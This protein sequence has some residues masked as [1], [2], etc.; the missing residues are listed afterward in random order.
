MT[1]DTTASVSR[2]RGTGRRKRRAPATAPG[3]I[4]PSAAAPSATP[5]MAGKMAGSATSTRSAPCRPTPRAHNRRG[6]ILDAAAEL[7][8]R[9][10]FHAASMREIGAAAGML[11]G[12]LYYHFPSK[13]ELLLA[14]YE[15]GVRRIAE[16]LDAALSE[17]DRPW[18][19]LEAAC[20]AHLEMLLEAG[21]DY[22]QVVIR[23]RPQDCPA[24]QARLIALRDAHED[25]FKALIEML[26]LPAEADRQA[27]RLM[28]LGALNWTQTWYRPG[29]DPP[30]TLARRFL[31]LVAIG[32][33]AV[34]PDVIAERYLTLF[35]GGPG[36]EDTP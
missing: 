28:M 32:P 30:A 21:G 25:R 12:S 35:A 15:E 4:S 29:G 11:P 13:D 8:A 34:P 19:R 14:V 2:A 24:M 3:A 36:A 1:S 26:E 6:E 20:V 33:G 9:Q 10:G 7:F 17:A 23:V 31:A 16:R 18:A 22:A 5:K 27:L